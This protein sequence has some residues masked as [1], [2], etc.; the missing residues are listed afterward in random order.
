MSIIKYHPDFGLYRC[1]KC[2]RNAHVQ[3]AAACTVTFQVND[4]GYVLDKHTSNES[5]TMDTVAECTDCGY[6][7]PLSTFLM[8]YRDERLDRCPDCEFPMEIPAD[9]CDA[10]GTP[11]PDA[12][13]FCRVCE[14]HTFPL[15]DWREKGWRC[16]ESVVVF[17]KSTRKSC[18]SCGESEDFVDVTGKARD[19]Y[20]LCR[21]SHCT[22]WW[23][24]PEDGHPDHSF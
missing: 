13:V 10:D 5:Y 14:G 7:G 20:M 3:L 23:A 18:P 24:E 21:C 19:G 16:L 11:K 1:P 15:A 4:D 2:E 9:D 12:T 17:Y 8:G 22:R 6:R